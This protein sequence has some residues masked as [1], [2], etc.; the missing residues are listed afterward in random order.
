VRVYDTHVANEG[1]G[2]IGV[3]T[4]FFADEVDLFS[5][6]G[7]IADMIGFYAGDQGH[8]TRVTSKAIGY[9]AGNMTAGAP[10]TVGFRSEMQAG[11][12]KFGFL[13]EGS[14]VNQFRGPVAIGSAT[15]PVDTLE[16]FQGYAKLCGSTTKFAT[17]SYHEM[18]TANNAAEIAVISHTG[19]T[20]LGI[21][22]RM[23]QAA[24]DATGHF[25]RCDSSAAGDVLFI[26][27]N[28]DVVNLNN[29]YGAISDE[30]LKD[31]I[32]PAP[33]VLDKFRARQFVTYRLKTGGKTMRGVI[34]QAEQAISPELVTE[35]DHLT[36]NYAGLAVETAQAVQELLTLVDS[37]QARIAQLEA[38]S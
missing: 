38:R 27:R 36:Y 7:T 19:T 21:R 3:A 37:L 5:G 14:A 26:R 22:I 29:S 25:L 24:N 35:N 6:T 15:V 20:P 1:T 13:S 16:L 34:A 8:A 4:C 2:N 31:D 11:T 28:G 18:R 17:G 33:A 23:D 9:N 12:G 10:L 32:A 30:R